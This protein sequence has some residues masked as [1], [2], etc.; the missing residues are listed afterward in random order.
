MPYPAAQEV[1]V[2]MVDLRVAHQRSASK[3]NTDV[4]EKHI[5]F[6][7]LIIT[8]TFQEINARMCKKCNPKPCYILLHWLNLIKWRPKPCFTG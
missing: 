3:L 2:T 4:E 6:L 1:I 5:L 8:G 7:L